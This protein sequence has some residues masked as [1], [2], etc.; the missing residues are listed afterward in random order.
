MRIAAEESVHQDYKFPST[1]QEY[2][3]ERYDQPSKG[4]FERK[5]RC[6]CFEDVE[7]IRSDASKSTMSTITAPPASG[8]THSSNHNATV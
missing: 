1:V 5:L 8:L 4:N 2:D 6:V 7:D 3:Q